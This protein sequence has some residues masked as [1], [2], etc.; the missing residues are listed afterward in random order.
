[1]TRNRTLFLLTAALVLAADVVTKRLIVAHMFR[2]DVI[3][4]VGDWVRLTYIHN[5]GAAFGLFPGSRP[6]LIA[7]SLVA[8]VVV[9]VVGWRRRTRLHTVLPLALILGGA[10]GNLLDRVR[11]GQVVDFVQIGI[12]PD[13]YWPVFNVADSAVTLG[14]V[15][16][17]LGILFWHKE[18]QESETLPEAAA[19]SEGPDAGNGNGEP[20]KHPYLGDEES[21]R[22]VAPSRD[23]R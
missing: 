20:G 14:V 19:R 16:L 17:A 4:V 10:L 21:V 12:P 22:A 7:V 1:M 5:P 18:E 6:V 11:M 3:R 23:D 13:T 2:G 15:W 9:S 8:V